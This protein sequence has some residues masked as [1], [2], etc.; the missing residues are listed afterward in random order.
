MR[1]FLTGGDQTTRLPLR[2][3][4]GPHQTNPPLTSADRVLEASAHAAVRFSRLAS[5]ASCR[6]LEEIGMQV[7]C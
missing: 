7:V 4:G 3:R 5:G 6:L 2:Q 1:H